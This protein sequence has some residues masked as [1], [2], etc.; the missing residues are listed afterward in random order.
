[1][2]ERIVVTGGAGFLGSHLC[3]RL[4]G[5]G[6]AVVC[7]DNLST[8]SISNVRALLPRSDFQLIEQDITTDLTVDGQVDAILH[9]ASIASPAAYRT[10]PVETMEA[11]SVGTKLVIELALRKRCRFLL[12]S[13]SEI[14]GD[15]LVHPQDETYNGNVN[16][17][18]P[19]AMYTEAK[20][21]AE[22]ITSVYANRY[23]L[24]AG[25]ARIFN[26]YGPRL[27]ANDGRVV[28]TFIRQALAQEPLTV[29]GDGEQTRSFCYVTDAVEGLIRLLRSG[30]HQPVNIGNPAEVSVLNLA[31]T[32]LAVSKSS[33]PVRFVPMED[34]DPRRR[35]PDIALARRI[36]NWEPTVTLREGLG[37]TVDHVVRQEAANSLA[38]VTEP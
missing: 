7:V 11:G 5:D 35:R 26:T 17:I 2:K 31:Y 30:Y 6:A 16:P 38:S 19:R 12:A 23:G 36:L 28:S 3:E 18:G 37:R 27:R 13:S 33:S 32:V 15:S 1:M 9:F 14:Y 10:F 22:A 29:M 4:L 21:Y 8:G 34:D 24:N 25:T 20:R